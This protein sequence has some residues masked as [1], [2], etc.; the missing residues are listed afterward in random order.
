[1]PKTKARPY[2]AT[3]AGR[4]KRRRDDNVESREFAT[5]C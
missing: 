3:P 4:R 2:A 5:R 1:M